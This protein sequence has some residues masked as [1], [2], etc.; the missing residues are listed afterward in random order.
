MAKMKSRCTPE[1]KVSNVGDLLAKDKIQ[2]TISNYQLKE[3]D[4]VVPKHEIIEKLKFAD[5][6]AQFQSEVKEQPKAYFDIDKKSE[7]ANV[8]F[9]QTWELK[10]VKSKFSEAA[11]S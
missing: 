2:G 10:V 1:R 8:E 6:A 3:T 9:K 11:K 5:T 4:T 7:A